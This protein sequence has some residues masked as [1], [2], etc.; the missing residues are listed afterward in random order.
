ML[1]QSAFDKNHLCLTYVYLNTSI[2]VNG[3]S[4]VAEPAKN[5]PAIQATWV[6]FLGEEDPLERGMAT[7][8]HVLAWRIPWTE[9]P[10]GL[11]SMGS[12]RVRHD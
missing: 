3:A 11:K 7:H 4:Q 9:Q 5:L 2:S 6:C 1:R 8:S 12:Q 10:G